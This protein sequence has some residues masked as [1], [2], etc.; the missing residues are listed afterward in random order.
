MLAMLPLAVWVNQTVPSGDAAMSSGPG[1]LGVGNVPTTPVTGSSRPTPCW[2]VNLEVNQIWPSVAMVIC[3]G[4]SP[5]TGNTS[6]SPDRRVET[7][8]AA[9]ERCGEPHVAHAVHDQVSG[10]GARELR[11][12]P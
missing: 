1:W 10:F 3:R 8:D 7:V 2:V 4:M 5:S 9:V 12:Q 6:T 11:E